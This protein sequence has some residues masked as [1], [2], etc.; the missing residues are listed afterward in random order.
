[1][2]KIISIITALIL[3]SAMLGCFE[4]PNPDPPGPAPGKLPL[5]IGVYDGAVG[6]EWALQIEKLYEELN[7]DVDVIVK[8]KK[9][10]YDDASLLSKISYNDEDIYFASNNSLVNLSRNGLVA[11]LSEFIEEKIYDNNGDLSDNPTQSI[12]DTMWREWESFC[13]VDGKFYAIPNFSPIAG[14]IYDA[15]LFNEKRYEVPETYQEL[16]QLMQRMVSDSITPFT[17]A[18]SYPYIV[19][20]AMAFYANYEGKNDF[21]LNTTFSGT[22]D[23]FGDI[24]LQNAYKL[25]SQAGRKAYLQFYHDLAHNPNFTTTG[26]RGSQTH[27]NSQDTFVS[28]VSADKRIAML[29][30]NSFWER[31][32]KGTI[33]TLGEINSKWGWGKRNF[34]YMVAPIDKEVDR[35][36]VYVSYPYS[37]TFMN[38]KS[39]RLELAKDF[40]QFVQSRKGLA[41]YTV[42]SGCLRPFN[43][44]ITDEEYA[45]ATPFTRS[46]IDLT[47]RE[48]IDFATMGAGTEIGRNLGGANYQDEWANKSKTAYNTAPH[49]LPFSAFIAY[50]DLTVDQYF[51]GYSTYMTEQKYTSIYNSVYGGNA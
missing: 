36:T 16:K 9:T 42:Y 31:E 39:E 29:I 21:M 47:R 49:S 4:R 30:E 44:T 11:D 23:E 22:D 18:N 2:K 12:R 26:S 10:E 3:V 7:P 51:D 28:S 13:K 25:Q 34:K 8:H 6:Y 19:D 35:Q 14:L 33:D 46:L 45:S 5:Y 43:Y 27:L 24:N 41:T 50:S 40:L 15:D 48:D 20:A 37:Y 17:V 1:M 32:A 38:A